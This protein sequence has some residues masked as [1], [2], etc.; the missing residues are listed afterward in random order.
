MSL[1]FDLPGRKK[2]EDGAR[3]GLKAA[4]GRQ[5]VVAAV[6]LGASKVACFIMKASGVDAEALTLTAAGVVSV[7]ICTINGF[8]NPANEQA[9]AAVLRRDVRAVRR[10]AL[11]ARGDREPESGENRREGHRRERDAVGHGKPP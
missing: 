10:A 4:L 3:S 2:R 5:P 7:A 1:T 8:R 6:D 9:I 11:R